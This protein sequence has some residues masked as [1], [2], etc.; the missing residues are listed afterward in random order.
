MAGQAL[1]TQSAPRAPEL[2]QD[3]LAVGLLA[4]TVILMTGLF[5]WLAT[6]YYQLPDLLPLH[7]D[8]YGNPDRIGERSEIFV[9]PAIGL[10]VN[11]VNIGIGLLLRLRLRM[12]FASYLLWSGALLMQVLLWIAALNITG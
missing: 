11:T 4:A 8:V 5:L 6:V 12:V 1:T 10:V 9:L 2:K 7:F 3:F